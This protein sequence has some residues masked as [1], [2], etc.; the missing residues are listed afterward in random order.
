MPRI[1]RADVKQVTGRTKH[2]LGS[3]IE[4]VPVPIEA[5]PQPAWVEIE[6]DPE[7]FFL[8][9]FNQEGEC[10]AD[11]WHESL[12]AAKKQAQFEFCIVEK[13]WKDIVPG[14]GRISL[15]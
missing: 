1:L 11:T 14:K 4:G 7:G 3:I 13:D 9:R 10:L 5:I 6:S 2:S 15:G 12:E 8:L